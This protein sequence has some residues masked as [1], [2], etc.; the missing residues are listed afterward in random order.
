MDQK[1]VVEALKKLRSETKE[2]KFKQSVELIVNLKD[3]NLKNPDEQ[4]EFFTNTPNPFQKRKVCAIVDGE[5][6]EEAKKTCDKVIT[7]GE[8]SEYQKDKKLTKKL[9]AEYDYFI[10]QANIMGKVAGTFG[11]VLG[12]RGKMPNPKAGCVVPPKATLGPLYE[13]LQSTV[14]VSA[15]KFPVIQLK[16]GTEEM[17][18]EDIAKNIMYFYGQIEHHLPKE[19]HN[20]KGALVKFTMSKPIK[21]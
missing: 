15:K 2:R 1:S 13:R 8:L 20:I 21:L 7:V 6:L 9:G 11:R 18:D 4:V 12:P 10:A 14:K 16:I 17:S 5:L 19:R 3:L